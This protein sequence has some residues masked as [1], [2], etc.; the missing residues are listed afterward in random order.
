MSR[1]ATYDSLPPH[2]TDDEA[3]PLTF[4]IGTYASHPLVTITEVQAHLRLLGA[5]ATLKAH[6]Q[7]G[8]PDPQHAWSVFVHK[9]VYRFDKFMSGAWRDFP[10]WN[11]EII[12]PLDVVMVWHTYL[13]NPWTYHEDSVR[14][15]TP[16][17]RR[18]AAMQSMP[19]TLV[20]SLIDPNT[21]EPLVPSYHRESFFELT[22]GL[23]FM[24]ATSTS[25][26]DVLELVCPCCNALNERVPWITADG[27]GF[28]ETEFAYTCESCG[29]S[30][31][32]ETMGVRKFCEEA[33]RHRAGRKVYFAN[34][35][36]D[37][38]TGKED[39]MLAE[40]KSF[41]IVQRIRTVFKLSK[42]CEQDDIVPQATE[43]AK[44]LD[45]STEKVVPLLQQA[46]YAQKT[47]RRG[48]ATTPFVQRI[49]GA[50]NNAGYASLD[51]VGAVIRQGS[52]VKAIEGLGWLNARRFTSGR[53]QAPLFQAISRYHSFLDL[54]TTK[55][56]AC[57]IPTLDIDLV[58]HTH[59]LSGAAYRTDTLRLLNRVL[60]HDDTIQ[61][62]TFHAGYAATST[63]WTKRFNAAYSTCGCVPKD[64][65]LPPIISITTPK[66]KSK[67][68][69]LGIPTFKRNGSVLSFLTVEG[70]NASRSSLFSG[71][72]PTSTRVGRPS[73][74]ESWLAPPSVPLVEAVEEEDEDGATH[75]S[76]HALCFNSDETQV[77]IPCKRRNIPGVENQI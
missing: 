69:W 64:V 25:M 3:I 48:D 67:G 43:L 1:Q 57:P 16:F 59:Q 23:S 53:T 52:F 58:W 39:E 46:I 60:K 6:V 13:L 68:G 77:R 7:R 45:W 47:F 15:T 65:I 26:T 34:T 21:F 30:F 12:P 51:L 38:N 54:L 62:S 10:P 29:R 14:R 63:A 11:E 32:R 4:T 18:L 24:Y 72:S 55:A 33:T 76:E 8:V 42:V 41:H 74:V 9:A 49:L 36:V 5:F 61:P 17:A 22:S 28:G 50:Y 66:A 27:K 37:S 20:A 71:I 2:Y 70:R 44:A 35:L 56:P 75:P 40:M 19:I 73:D 31:N